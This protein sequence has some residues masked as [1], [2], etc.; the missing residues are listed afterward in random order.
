MALAEPTIARD[1][2]QNTTQ[3]AAQNAAVADEGQSLIR[4]SD[5]V[6]Y[7]TKA[8][9]VLWMLRSIVGD[10]ALRRTLQAYREDKLDNDPKEFQRVLERTAKRDLAWFF[11]DWVYRDRGLPRPKHRQRHPAPNRPDR[12]QGLRLARRSRSTQRRW[13]SRRGP[14]DRTLWNIDSNA[15]VTRPRPLQCLHKDRLR[16]HTRTRCSSTTAPF[17]K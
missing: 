1:A 14:R 10:D 5:E 8:A 16:R 4:A 13:R 9:A 6:Y 12:Q 2:A 7:R 17:P 3:T 11:D 15:K